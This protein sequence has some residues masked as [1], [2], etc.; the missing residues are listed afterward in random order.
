MVLL[1]EIDKMIDD[2]VMYLYIY[3]RTIEDDE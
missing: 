2:N 3:N 1:I